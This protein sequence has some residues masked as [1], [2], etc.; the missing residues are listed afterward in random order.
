MS[1]ESNVKYLD[2]YKNIKKDVSEIIIITVFIALGMNII[3][4]GFSY[5]LSINSF[6]VYLVIGLVIICFASI[7]WVYSQIKS[8]NGHINVRGFFIYKTKTKSIINIP[9]YP[10]S[11]D[12]VR[13]L[14]SAFSE[15]EAIKH[16]WENSSLKTFD[17]IDGKRV[18]IESDAVDIVKELIEYSILFQFSVYLTDYFNHCNMKKERLIEYERKDI[19]DILLEN[20]FLH[21]FSE[22]MENR[23]AFIKANVGK[24]KNNKNIIGL[25]GPGDIQFS[26]FSLVLPKKTQ[27]SKKDD[28]SILIDMKNFSLELKVIFGGFSAVVEKEFYENYL[29]IKKNSLDEYKEYEFQVNIRIKYKLNSFFLRKWEEYNWLDSV[30]NQLIEYISGNNFYSKINWDTVKAILKGAKN[31]VVLSHDNK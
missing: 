17:Y 16:N 25:Y 18:K 8:L 27:I 7:F 1:K 2:S 13:N 11:E 22:P 23:A 19:P 6:W 3:S 24:T 26:K 15:N 31:Q 28:G 10:I 14:R 4:F 20:R 30:I 12:M 5:G 9:E 29:G 21:L